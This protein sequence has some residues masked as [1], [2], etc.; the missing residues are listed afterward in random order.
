MNVLFLLSNKINFLL[1]K[2]PHGTHFSFGHRPLLVKQKSVVFSFFLVFGIS[3]IFGLF[4]WISMQIIVI[5]Y[6]NESVCSLFCYFIYL[7]FKRFDGEKYYMQRT[8]QVQWTWNSMKNVKLLFSQKLFKYFECI[9]WQ[10]LF[11]SLLFYLF[12]KYL[13]VVIQIMFH[14]YWMKISLVWS[15]SNRLIFNSI[16]LIHQKS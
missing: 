8:N 2:K 5:P 13:E 3:F 16:L 4:R 1:V 14:F 6:T 15:D 12:H 7:K 11:N 10:H 9:W